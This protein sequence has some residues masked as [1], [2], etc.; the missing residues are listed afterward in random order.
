MINP[1]NQQ[2]S[3]S[4]LRR[5]EADLTTHNFFKEPFPKSSS[6][7]L[8][9]F[10]LRNRSIIIIESENIFR[11][12]FEQCL[13]RT[14]ELEKSAQKKATLMK[15]L[16]I[17]L[18]VLGIICAA[19]FFLLPVLGSIAS[20]LGLSVTSVMIAWQAIF[21]GG[22]LLSILS[23]IPRQFM[24]QFNQDKNHHHEKIN[25]LKFFAQE[26]NFRRFLEAELGGGRYRYPQEIVRAPDFVELYYLL[27]S[28][29]EK[30]RDIERFEQALQCSRQLMRSQ[31]NHS[32]E[33]QKKQ[34]EIGEKIH[35]VE[36]KLHE[37][38]REIHDLGNEINDLRSNLINLDRDINHLVI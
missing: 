29:N 36:K 8:R 25:T 30:R 10:S 6:E 37:M 35:D 31:E 9:D 7:E 11:E 4:H 19:S 27:F 5:S 17:G 16:F 22:G 13:L 20:V 15:V 26:N 23:F 18:L 33:D 24:K 32:I 1:L 12:N 21:L 2:A 38:N 28:V 34:K 14:E 3:L